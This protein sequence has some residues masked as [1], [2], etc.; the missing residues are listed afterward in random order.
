MLVYRSKDK[1]EHGNDNDHDPR[2]MNKLRCDKNAEHNKR[3]KGSDRVYDKR[4]PPVLARGDFVRNKVRPVNFFI[5]QL[6]VR[7]CT[8]LAWLRTHL[9]VFWRRFFPSFRKDDIKSLN[10]ENGAYIR[11]L[12]FLH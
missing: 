3:R 6:G 10:L 2:T 11:S 4:L 12:L 1:D 5:L 7:Q 9:R 8:G